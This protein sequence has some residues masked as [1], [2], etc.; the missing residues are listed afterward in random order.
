MTTDCS[1]IRDADRQ[2]IGAIVRLDLREIARRDG[3]S[4]RLTYYYVR[5]GYIASLQKMGK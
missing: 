2:I 3:R 5:D 1:W 4:M